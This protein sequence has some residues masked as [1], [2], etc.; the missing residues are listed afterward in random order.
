MNLLTEKEREEVRELRSGSYYGQIGITIRFG[1]HF[2]HECSG[3]LMA[4]ACGGDNM[5]TLVQVKK[6]K[7]EKKPDTDY[8]KKSKTNQSN[9][10]VLNFMGSKGNN[11]CTQDGTSPTINRM[12]GSDVH[13]VCIQK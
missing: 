3:S 12:H 7:I 4:G 6:Q 10:I 1:N 5:P 2:W 9:P 8:C 11:V 13:V